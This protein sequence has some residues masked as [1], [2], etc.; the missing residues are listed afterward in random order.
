ML[1]HGMPQPYETLKELTRGR[2]IDRHVIEEFIA[3]L[4]LDDA[5]KRAL[6]ELNPRSYVGLA[7]KL[8]EQFAPPAKADLALA[9]KVRAAKR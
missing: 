9:K 7:A 8:V 6:R 2:R 1:R 4:P 5:A 3:T